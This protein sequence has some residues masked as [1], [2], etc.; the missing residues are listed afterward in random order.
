MQLYKEL[1]PND[2]TITQGDL[3]LYKVERVL[4]NHPYN[5]LGLLARKKLIVLAEAESDWS[6]NII[7]RLAGYYFDSMEQFATQMG[8]NSHQKA[9]IDLLD[10]E[11]FIVYPGKEDV[12]DTIS[13]R[14]VFF[15]GDESKPDFKAVVIH[16][17]IEPGILQE[18]MG[19][20]RVLDEQR[21]LHRGDPTPEKW[22]EVTVKESI[23]RGF[24]VNYLSDHKTEVQKI[25]F[26]MYNPA[27]VEEMERKYQI[28]MENIVF[29]R[30]IGVPD[31]KIKEG[32]VA[33]FGITPTYAQNLL[34]TKPSE[35][36][37]EAV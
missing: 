10:V 8:M 19:F 6:V 2:T 4:T 15:G 12:P 35:H 3:E 36:I 9:K 17:D 28:Y 7:Y 20:C 30:S 18:Y 24:L 25:M 33:R 22:I 16:G 11:A 29:C 21:V 37:V 23:K 32:L 27:Y 1:F 5:D 34:D 26:D 31:E 14:E 13:L